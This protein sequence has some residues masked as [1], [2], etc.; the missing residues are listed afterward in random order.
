[1]ALPE[2]TPALIRFDEEQMLAGERRRLEIEADYTARAVPID[3]FGEMRGPVH[4]A[5]L[6]AWNAVADHCG[7]PRIPAEVIVSIPTAT[8]WKAL[9][10]PGNMTPEEDA[11]IDA[12]VCW[13]QNGRFW[14]TELCSS[15]GVKYALGRDGSYP[16]ADLLAFTLDDCRIMDMH[17]GMPDI[18]V[19]GRPTVEPARVK[20]WPVEFRV[21][22]GGQADTGAVSFYYPQAGEFAIT[23]KLQR[24]MDFAREYGLALYH[25]REAL[26]LVPWLPG[27]E[28]DKRIG[29][30]MDFML[31]AEG[32][33]VMVDAGPGYGCGAH[34]CCFIDVP[35]TGQ[36][37]RLADGVE[38]R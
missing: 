35:V 34:P 33:L 4:A 17:W 7:V 38:L 6:L 15:E 2:I 8:A 5:S 24:A 20:G 1:M 19:I 16:S 9:D 28:P 10:E 23:A 32:E 14:R 37:W 31:T 29:A 3:R 26:G 18:K 27:S 11:V 25:A 12:A 22:C 21:F 36:R 13:C 30:T